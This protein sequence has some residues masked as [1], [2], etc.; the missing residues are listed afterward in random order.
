MPVIWY[1]F[2]SSLARTSCETGFWLNLNYN[3]CKI[4]FSS[5]SLSLSALAK[6]THLLYPSLSSS[7]FFFILYLNFLTTH[8]NSPFVC[9][10]FSV[11]APLWQRRDRAMAAFCWTLSQAASSALPAR[12]NGRSWRN[13]TSSS[14][15]PWCRISAWQGGWA[16]ML[17]RTVATWA[18]WGLRLQV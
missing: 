8:H 16:A 18:K 7:F 10:I 4:K 17:A 13:R 14:T 1:L 5:L 9:I 2:I 6:L 3:P 15:P 11:L 12:D